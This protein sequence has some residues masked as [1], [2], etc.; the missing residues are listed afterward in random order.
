MKNYYEYQIATA[1][2]ELAEDARRGA[3]HS[4]TDYQLQLVL[5][6]RE[7]IRR[8][9]MARQRQLTQLKSF[10]IDETVD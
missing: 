2:S 7:N 9:R 10:H 3:K 8:V 5:L 6:T 4:L 1:D